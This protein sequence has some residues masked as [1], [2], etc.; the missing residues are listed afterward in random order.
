MGKEGIFGIVFFAV[1]LVGAVNTVWQIYKIV[2]LDAESR[3]LK[4]PRLWGFFAANTNGS[5]GLVL[6][7]IGRRKY[8]VIRVSE[9]TR[10]EIESR[11]KRAGIGLV[12]LAVGMMGIVTIGVLI[13]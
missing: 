4:H 8:P 1:L 2:G 10:R 3:G 7:L 5:S 13:G 11:K 12:F 9:E 6:Y